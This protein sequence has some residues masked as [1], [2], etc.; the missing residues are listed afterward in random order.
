[1]TGLYFVRNFD[2]GE[3]D[4]VQSETSYGACGALGWCPDYCD[5]RYIG[6]VDNGTEPTVLDTP[7]KTSEED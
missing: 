2:T 4:T 3:S 1:M 7:A 6:E 5:V